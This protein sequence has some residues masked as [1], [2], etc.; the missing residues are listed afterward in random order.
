MHTMNDKII[1]NKL[2]SKIAKQHVDQLY[3][4]RINYIL[5][6]QK[7]LLMNLENFYGKLTLLKY[8]VYLIY[9]IYRNQI[10]GIV[11]ESTVLVFS[12]KTIEDNISTVL[13]VLQIFTILIGWIALW[14][15]FFMLL[16]S[17]S[18]SV[19]ENLWEF[20][21]LR[22][23]GLKKAQIVRIYLY[24]SLAVTISA[25]IM[26]LIIGFILAVTISLQFNIFLELPFFLEFPFVLVL[27]MVTLALIVT[28]FGTVIPIREVNKKSI[29][30]VLR[31]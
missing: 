31:G 30:W 13:F 11:G 6:L 25:W 10:R 1:E 21:V 7:T 8:L 19:K 26:G 14:I 22:A 28:V 17:I 27:I 18:S 24:E 5:K 29:S 4:Q 23:I 12:I 3:I 16:V 15:S 9:I 20:G 2:N